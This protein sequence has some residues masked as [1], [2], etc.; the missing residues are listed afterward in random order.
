M[1]KIS[2]PNGTKKKS[3]GVELPP[4]P[5]RKATTEIDVARAIAAWS[6]EVHRQQTTRFPELFPYKI[7]RLC[8][9][10]LG[11]LRGAACLFYALLEARPNLATGPD[12]DGW[13]VGDAHLENFGAYRPDHTTS[14]RGSAGKKNHDARFDLNDFDEAV[15]APWRLDVLRLSTSVLLA[16]RELGT[17]GLDALALCDRLIESWL[18]SAFDGASIPSPPAPV[19]ALV[20]QARG[21]SRRALLDGRTKIVDGKRRLERGSR[22]V[23]LPKAIMVRV[24]EALR[25][26]A[27][28]LPEQERPSEDSLEILDCALRVAGTGSLGCVRIAVLVKGK[29]GDDGAWI[30]DMKEAGE[31]AP[32]RYLSRSLTLDEPKDVFA[33]SPANRVVKAYRACVAEP[34]RMLGKTKIVYEGE[35]LSMI[36]RRLS[37]QEDKLNLERC[38]KSDLPELATYLGALLGTAHARAATVLPRKEGA[39]KA[40][41][42][43]RSDIATVREHAV[44]IAGTHEAV[45]LA[46]CDLTRGSRLF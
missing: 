34:P 31:P 15:I 16:G 3:D 22:Y 5:I 10:P 30:F 4:F 36:V 6:L 7:A 39:K 42:W 40:S 26:Y 44:A 12:G 38:K 11:F 2:K 37:P 9:S 24:P 14:D 27:E 41:K 25:R 32:H 13:I 21:R 19:R 46:L 29:G 28:K 45:Y 8:A 23:E 1:K 20:E 35:K 17:N 43:S 33:K 18:R